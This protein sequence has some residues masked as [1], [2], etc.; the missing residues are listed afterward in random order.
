MG[1]I[2]LAALL[3]VPLAL[4]SHHHEGPASRACAACVVAQHSPAVQAPPLGLD[5]PALRASSLPRTA[6]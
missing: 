4:G 3:L 5:T 1:S 2:V 6:P